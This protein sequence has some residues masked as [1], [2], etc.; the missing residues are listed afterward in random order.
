MRGRSTSSSLQADRGRH[1]AISSPRPPCSLEHGSTKERDR[2]YRGTAPRRCERRSRAASG[3]PSPHLAPA[4]RWAERGKGG[5]VGEA[6]RARGAR[7]GHG[8]CG[9][10]RIGALGRTSGAMRWPRAL[11]PTAGR[12]SPDSPKLTPRQSY[13]QLGRPRATVGASA[14]GV[15]GRQSGRQLGLTG[16]TVGLTGPLRKDWR[17]VT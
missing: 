4:S 2:P 8:R 1:D 12:L 11:G 6:V 17:V 5:S 16:A 15:A 9:L 14:R 7:L 10:R 13:R 3:H